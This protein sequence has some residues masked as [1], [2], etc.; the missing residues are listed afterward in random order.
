M[1]RKFAFAAVVMLAFTANRSARAGSAATGNINVTATVLAKCTIAKNGDLTFN[2]YDPLSGSATLANSKLDVVCT[3]NSLANVGISVGSTYSNVLGGALTNRRAMKAATAAAT[4]VDGDLL[5][6]DLFQPT[7]TVAN[8][9]TQSANT[10]GDGTNPPSSTKLTIAAATTKL[11]ASY[12]IFGSIPA[13][14]DVKPDTF[15]DVI[16]ATINF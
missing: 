5:A 16:V 12:S 8:G 10:W 11:T 9:G 1:T 7:N 13:G 4:P 6:Y 3:R 14:Q 15:S 2:T